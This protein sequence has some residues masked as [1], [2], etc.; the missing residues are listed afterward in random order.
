MNGMFRGN[1]ARLLV[2]CVLIVAAF[3]GSGCFTSVAPFYEESQV[4]QDA[5]MEGRHESYSGEESKDDS[6]WWIAASADQK[7][8]YDVR[9]RDGQVSIHLVGTLFR[10]ERM[11]FLDLY[12]VTDS[13]VRQA[14]PGVAVSEFVRAA[15]Y[16]RRHVVWKVEISDAAIKYSMPVKNGAYSAAKQAPE[17]KSHVTDDGTTLAFPGP[18]KESQKYLMRFADDASVFNFKGELRKMKEDGK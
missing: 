5:R 7:G 16:S 10:V 2:C 12:P 17:L 9:I 4:V 18:A 14:G 8:K 11:M 6:V 15:F 3:G 13:G 1:W